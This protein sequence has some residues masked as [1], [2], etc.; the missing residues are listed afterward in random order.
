MKPTASHFGGSSLEYR[1]IKA[2][3]WLTNLKP[4]YRQDKDIMNVQARAIE[5]KG[6]QEIAKGAAQ[7]QMMMQLGGLIPKFMGIAEQNKAKKKA[8]FTN[9][10]RQQSF[11]PDIVET[12][13]EA[14]KLQKE[15]L[16][17][18]HVELGKLAGWDELGPVLSDKILN[19][20]AAEQVI[21]K[22]IF[23]AQQ[24]I[25]HGSYDKFYNNKVRG[26]YKS[27]LNA[28][29]DGPDREAA[30]NAAYK[31]HLLESLH[32][33]APSDGVYSTVL[34]DEVDRLITT[35]NSKSTSKATNQIVDHNKAEFN[36][37]VETFGNL[38]DASLLTNSYQVA[39][40]K[41]ESR[42]TDIPG[43]ATAFQQGQE[44]L[45]KDLSTILESG[46]LP[47]ASQI[48]N[49]LLTSAIK[50]PA[51]T[52]IPQAYFDKDGV[53][54][55]MLTRA[56]EK[57]DAKAWEVHKAAVNK[58][59]EQDLL[60]ISGMQGPQARTELD[61]FL[62]NYSGQ[63]GINKELYN[64]AEKMAGSTFT[65]KE[66]EAKTIQFNG[67][68]DSGFLFTDEAKEII[69]NEP[70]PYIKSKYE[71]IR[72]E[73]LKIM[74]GQNIKD[75]DKGIKDDIIQN[76][77]EK[78]FQKSNKLTTNG[79]KVRIKMQQF[80]DEWK[81]QRI[82]SLLQPDGTYAP[83]PDFGTDYKEA[84]DAFWKANGGGGK[85]KGCVGIFC[86]SSGFNG[87]YKNITEFEEAVQGIDRAHKAKFTKPNRARWRQDVT[88]SDKY[89]KSEKNEEGYAS[90]KEV[91]KNV[92]EAYLSGEDLVGV[93]R[94]KTYSDEILAKAAL[95][96]MTPGE[97]VQ[98]QLNA[99]VGDKDFADFA[100]L[101]GLD[102]MT[103]LKPDLQM[104]L[105]EA[106]EGNKDVTYL[107]KYV[108]FGDL[109]EKQQARILDEAWVI[110][111][112]RY[113]KIETQV[114]ATTTEINRVLADQK[115]RKE[116]K[117]KNPMIPSADALPNNNHITTPEEQLNEILSR[118]GIDENT[119]RQMLVPSN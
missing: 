29:A 18:E 119:L 14:Y 20:S 77:N 15:G 52:T 89:I 105:A 3:D 117:K 45:L 36:Q 40:V 49:K 61:K 108:G 91:A 26:K 55:N 21:L 82:K 90:R 99:L 24:L 48:A 102:K 109:S 75:H 83:D 8:D 113:T 17:K 71:K 53:I 95:L 19:G 114:K 57:G 38:K 112:E 25:F 27:D 98:A 44:A 66:L 78:T 23:A 41:Y 2:T 79:K 104:D 97:L 81:A 56:A 73:G 111:K 43:G 85:G 31:Q 1:P 37:A 103:N 68:V 64:T 7:D 101:H 4:I 28:I 46:T 62:L 70:N 106:F 13:S 72:N 12:A 65:P 93:I 5:Q 63:P 69:N 76:I 11:T 16:L 67:Y 10:I 6:Q 94:N 51:G 32:P 115:I 118:L 88:D 54:Y 33:F 35:R 86:L 96:G 74:A 47:N 42:F 60:A 30:L 107:L 100:K 80:G 84:L 39:S 110:A 87:D 116:R 34:L 59:M 9:L 58:S 50:H 22:E 92:A